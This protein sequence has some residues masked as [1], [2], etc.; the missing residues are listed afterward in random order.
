MIE[1]KMPNVHGCSPPD[2]IDIA[3]KVGYDFVN[4][5]VIPMNRAGEAAKRR[6]D[7]SPEQTQF[8]HSRWSGSSSV[9]GS[10]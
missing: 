3:A 4:L 8:N 1:L 9:S 6:F 2:V 7:H 10:D 5:R